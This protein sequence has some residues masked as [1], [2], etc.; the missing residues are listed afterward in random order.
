[1]KINDLFET[2]D[3]VRLKRAATKVLQGVEGGGELQHS[4]RYKSFDVNTSKKEVE[5]VTQ[6][7]TDDE[8]QECAEIIADAFTDAGLTGWKIKVRLRDD[9]RGSNTTWF[10]AN[11][12]D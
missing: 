5:W 2:A 3:E 7:S 11:S 6:E 10:T 8:S 9:Y 12:K 1:M 4:C